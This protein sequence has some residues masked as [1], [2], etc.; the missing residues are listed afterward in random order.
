MDFIPRPKK[1]PA[2]FSADT[3]DEDTTPGISDPVVAAAMEEEQAKKRAKKAAEST[4]HSRHLPECTIRKQP[5]WDE[6]E[7]RGTTKPG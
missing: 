3:E 1:R 6:H 4:G 2:G 5:L 7:T